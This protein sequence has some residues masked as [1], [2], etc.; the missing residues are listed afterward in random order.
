MEWVRAGGVAQ[1]VERLPSNCIQIPLL[2]K[3]KKKEWVKKRGN[4]LGDF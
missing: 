1:V 4:I 2:K 3:K